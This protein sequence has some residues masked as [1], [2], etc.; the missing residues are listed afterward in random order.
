MIDSAPSAPPTVV[1]VTVADLP[2]GGGNTS[3]LKSLGALVEAAGFATEIWN[4]HALGISPP[5]LLRAEGLLGCTPFRYVLGKT[6]R[7]YGFAAA[8]DKLG[9]VV[10]V[11]V[12]LCR[13]R[14]RVRGVWLNCLSFYDALPINL[15][16][17][18]LGVRCV[19][20]HEDERL[21][22]IY[23]AQM[24]PARK[25]F[26]L[27]SWIGDRLVVRLAS[28]VV[29]IS[30]Y[31]RE[32]YAR[33]SRRP[34]VIIPTLIDFAEWPDLPYAP[35]EGPRRCLYTGALGEQDAMEEVLAAFA[36]LRRAGQAFIFDI[37]GDSQRGPERRTR[38]EQLVAELDLA[39]C[40]VLHGYQPRREILA[41]IQRADVLIGIRRA[42]QLAFSGLS[43]KVS[44]YLA[45]GRA[46]I[47]STVGDGGG[48]LRAG[49]N[50]LLVEHPEQPEEFDRVLATALDV[51]A[52]RLVEIGRNGRHLARERFA[53]EAHVPA[54]RQ[55]F[56]T[57]ES[58][59]V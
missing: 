53:I 55:I 12:G 2:E 4:E 46:T 33:Y 18:L 9:A 3:R 57:A 32:K 19:Q 38:L 11:I 42:N 50:C 56:G 5:S 35:A 22:I 34:M 29:V 48:Y 58:S 47:A 59:S 36:R 31:L 43:T 30:S 44:E 7:R 51:P 39:S 52:K 21:E 15:V 17:L 24:S 54:I 14:R 1:F 20:A 16:C 37:Y 28:T 25:L 27:N 45:S 10:R 13:E 49:E 6:T 23:A 40:V 26:A 8:G 41:A